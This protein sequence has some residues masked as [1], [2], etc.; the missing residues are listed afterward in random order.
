MINSKFNL[1]IV[2][3]RLACLSV[4]LSAAA[5]T[6]KTMAQTFDYTDASGVTCT[7]SPTTQN[8]IDVVHLTTLVDF[9]ATVTKW[10]LPEMVT[11]SG[12]TYRLTRV[13]A[14]IYQEPYHLNMVIGSGLTDIVCPKYLQAFDSPL[15]NWNGQYLFPN[16]RKITFGE[17]MS[18]PMPD[19]EYLPLETV[20]FLGKKIIFDVGNGAV[21]GGDGSTFDNCP[22]DTKIIIPCGTLN[23]FLTAFANPYTYWNSWT[24]A[25]FEEAECLITL[26]VLSSNAALGNAMS[27]NS[28]LLLTTTIPANPN[29]TTVQFSGVAQLLALP[30][31]GNV[32]VGWNDGN[33]DNPRTVNVTADA[34]YTAI[35]AECETSG[36]STK[37]SAGEMQTSHMQVFP[38][39]TV[40]ILQVQF[41][42]PV[43][44]GI[45]TLYDMNGKTVLSQSASGEAAQINLSSLSAGSYILRL[46]ENG[47]TSTGIKVIKN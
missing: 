41:E 5:L 31:A 26:T 30:K 27:L 2:A 9:P 34:T 32:F 25:N 47:V 39:P 28:D 33:T 37:T 23:D 12:T 40:N 29:R 35:F 16:L 43:R 7:Y 8:G 15:S 4:L 13:G 14:Y 10:V 19:C 21:L 20:I 24:A 1:R 3:T 45:L 6:G 11:H 42:T 36:G 38:N 17:D 22:A 46:V 44:N 18:I